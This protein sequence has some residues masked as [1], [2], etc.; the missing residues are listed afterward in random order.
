MHSA[1]DRRAR[2]MASLALVAAAIGFAGTA[3]A[4]PVAYSFSTGPV[5]SATW[6]GSGS[7]G[8]DLD[9]FAALNGLSVTGT[10][11]YDNAVPLSGT[12]NGPVVFGQS[13]YAGAVSGVTGN[14]GS[15]AFAGTATAA[16]GNVANEG[17]MPPTLPPPAPLPVPSDFFQLAS[18]AASPGQILSGYTLVSARLF[19]IEG[20]TDGGLT[21]DFLSG[22]DLLEQLPSFAGR[23]ALDFLTTTPEGVNRL[24]T[25]FFDELTVE[26]EPVPE[27]GTLALLGLGGAGL[28]GLA[29]RRRRTVSG[30]ARD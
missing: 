21:P 28:L 11:D 2:P 10:F 12:T 26:T 18:T 30:A 5:T 7:S 25:A 27:P 22:N 9:L 14:V 8:L 19:W 3:E 1:A 13:N 15:L 6:L 24:H 29:R 16:G 23:F 20:A 17:Y 4:I